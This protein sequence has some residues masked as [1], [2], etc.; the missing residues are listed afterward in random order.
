[1]RT[2]K[3]IISLVLILALVA[4]FAVMVS[5]NAGASSTGAGLAEWA[6]RAYNEGWN[7]VYGGS[8]VGSVDCSG[9]LYS[10]CGGA[11]GADAQFG[12]AS[13]YG[14]MSNGIPNIHGLGVYQDGHVGVY[15]GGGMAVDARGDDYGVCYQSVYTKAWLYWFKNSAVSYPTNGWEKFNGDYYYYE[16]GEYIT[17]T[18]RTIDGV[19]YYFDSNGVSS[20]KP[21]SSSSSNSNKNQNSSKNNSSSNSSSNSNVIKLGSSGDAVTKLQQRLSELGFY[22]GDI[23]GYFGEL[24]QEAYMEF[25][26][27]AGVTVDGISGLSDQ[28][29]LYSDD[30]PFKQTDDSAFINTTKKQT[31]IAETSGEKVYRLGDSDDKVKEIQQRLTEL[32]YY[33]GDVNGEFDDATLT[34][35]DL[36]QGVNGV[37]QTGYADTFSQ[38]VL[39]SIAAVSNPTPLEDKPE[40]TEEPTTAPT[41]AEQTKSDVEATEDIKATESNKKNADTANNGVNE[42]TT[43]VVLH[44]TKASNK[45]LQGLANNADF[46]K[47]ET[48]DKNFTFIIWLAVMVVVMLISFVVIYIHEKKKVTARRARIKARRYAK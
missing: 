6:L 34:A 2:A 33:N 7:Y 41:E 40:D 38:E 31:D 9:L 46:T 15:V 20:N 44:T 11:R 26:E 28:Q 25:Q 8:S 42:T 18:Q 29:L 48:P 12:S 36:F 17:D 37:A 13:D 30:A 45:A 3:K 27:A 35:F 14:S 43:D 22:D 19:T 10:Y 23:T 16:N 4:S 21:S 5:F 39:F 24:T 1:M 32:G 47:V